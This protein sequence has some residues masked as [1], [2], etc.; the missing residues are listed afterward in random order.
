MSYDDDDDEEEEEE[1]P[2][3]VGSMQTCDAADSPRR[4]RQV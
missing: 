4:L 1:D 3:N 2:R